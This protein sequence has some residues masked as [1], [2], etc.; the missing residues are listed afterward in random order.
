[1]GKINQCMEPNTP[2]G[3]FFINVLLLRFIDR[4]L[5]YKTVN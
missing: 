3:Y 1:M 4:L 5:L 2:V